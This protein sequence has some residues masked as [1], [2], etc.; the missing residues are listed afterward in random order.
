MR[1]Q[2]KE[3]TSLKMMS[4]QMAM[5]IMLGFNGKAVKIAATDLNSQ[6]EQLTETLDIQTAETANEENDSEGA[7]EAVINDEPVIEDEPIINEEPVV[8][9][10]PVIE[11]EPIIN[12]EPVIEGDPE[13]SNTLEVSEQE[14]ENSLVYVPKVLILDKNG[15]CD[16]KIR[17][18]GTLLDNESIEVKPDQTFE[19]SRAG[20]DQ[21]YEASV[22]QDITTFIKEMFNSEGIVE[23]TG[24]IKANLGKPGSYSGTFQ[25]N[26]SMNKNE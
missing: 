2:K 18:S 20:S 24:H 11:E 15:E 6:G 4:L 21:K 23:T 10:E 25:F 19:M 5:I 22:V 12:E 7:D 3:K 13:A 1:L 17:V 8:E 26:I 9:E 14:I 16:Y